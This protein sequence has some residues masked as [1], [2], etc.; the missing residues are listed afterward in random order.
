MFRRYLRKTIEGF[1]CM[2][3]YLAMVSG[4]FFAYVWLTAQVGTA[5]KAILILFIVLSFIVGFMD[6]KGGGKNA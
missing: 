4:A 3:V 5:T 1:K 6:D 2:L